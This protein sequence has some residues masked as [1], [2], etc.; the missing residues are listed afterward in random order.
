MWLLLIFLL[1]YFLGMVLLFIFFLLCRLVYACGH[2]CLN[3]SNGWNLKSLPQSIHL[4]FLPR[5]NYNWKVVR[6]SFWDRVHKLLPERNFLVPFCPCSTPQFILLSFAHETN[7]RAFILKRGPRGPVWWNK[8][9][10]LLLLLMTMM[11]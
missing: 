11:V 10:L 8:V 4:G 3:P 7:T 2:L 5:T 1:I 9:K 6:H